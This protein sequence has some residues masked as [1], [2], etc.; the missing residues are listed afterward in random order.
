[1]SAFYRFIKILAT[2]IIKPFYPLKVINREKLDNG[3]GVLVCN[4]FRMLDIILVGLTCKEQVF[5][6]GKKELYK[7]RFTRWLFLK[8][9]SIPIDR[10]NNDVKA[11]MKIM[12]TLKEDK[13]IS[14]FPEGTR[15][16]EDDE[17]KDVKSGAAM[18]AVKTKKPVYPMMFHTRSRFLRK[19]YLIIGD[20]YEYTEL[21][22]KKLT[23]DD[24]DS[25]GEIMRE[26]MLSLQREVNEY[27]KNKK[28]KNKDAN[29]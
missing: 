28:R 19:N 17:L 29:N 5:F 4:H 18:F 9:G 2:I 20:K 21:Y 7:N 15:N 3:G 22:D 23:P 11:M 24:I 1:M 13:K 27:V 10:E 12:K 25:A 16:K 6:V 14:I 26:K 8:L